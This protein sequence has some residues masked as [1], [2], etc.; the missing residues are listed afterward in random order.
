MQ[1]QP[2]VLIGVPERIVEEQRRPE[3]AEQDV[4]QRHPDGEKELV[5]GA[6]RKLTPAKRVA[7]CPGRPE[8]EPGR[9]RERHRVVGRHRLQGASRLGRQLRPDAGA[10]VLD[11]RP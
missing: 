3:G 10:D 9:F 6:V 11:G 7:V 8:S 1:R 5:E 4:R 2:A